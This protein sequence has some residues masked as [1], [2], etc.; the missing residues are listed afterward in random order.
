MTALRPRCICHACGALFDEPDLVTRR[1]NLDGE[2]GWRTYTE[3][4]CPI[5]GED[6]FETLPEEDDEDD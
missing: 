6:N 4:L 3:A 1:E 2:R 5:C